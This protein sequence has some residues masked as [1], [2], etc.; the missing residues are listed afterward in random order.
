MSYEYRAPSMRRCSHGRLPDGILRISD[1]NHRSTLLGHLNPAV[2][3]GLARVTDTT[4]THV[5]ALAAAV[6]PKVRMLAFLAIVRQEGE[7]R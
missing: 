3:R 2:A 7:R 4:P 6:H 1:P 5:T